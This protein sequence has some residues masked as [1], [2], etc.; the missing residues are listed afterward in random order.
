MQVQ[1]P[2]RMVL[3]GTT[4][5]L[6]SGLSHWVKRSTCLRTRAVPQHSALTQLHLS[7]STANAACC[8]VA[9]TDASNCLLL[10]LFAA[11]GAG[12][13]LLNPVTQ[14]PDGRYVLIN[15]NISVNSVPSMDQSYMNA[16][17]CDLG[18]H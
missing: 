8:P 15:R 12:R 6:P 1:K 5:S 2:L 7:L 13:L 17:A 9:L 4:V 11:Y 10:P 18:Q 3:L 14:V 16:G